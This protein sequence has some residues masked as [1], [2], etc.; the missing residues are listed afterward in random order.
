MI[1][2]QGYTSDSPLT[3]P[4]TDEKS[5]RDVSSIIE[6]I[7]ARRDGHSDSVE[8]WASY[9]LNEDQYVELLRRVSSDKSLSGYIEH[10]LRYGNARC[11][12]G[13]T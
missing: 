5:L 12:N 2:P 10:K 9:T 11:V 13:A 1:P 6:E 8:P 3:P 7:S 4:P